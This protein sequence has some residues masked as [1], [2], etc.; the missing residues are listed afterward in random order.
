[1]HTESR[2]REWTAE[3]IRQIIRREL[4][5]HYAELAQCRSSK[6]LHAHPLYR[7]LK[8]LVR[9]V[10]ESPEIGH[11][12]EAEAPAREQYRFG[13]WN[14]ERGIQ[15]DSQIEAFRTHD[16][17]KRCD[18]LL[19]TETDVG[20]ARTANR[21]I[22]RTLARALGMHYAF[23]PCYL[24]L[25]KGA[26]AEQDVGG[27]NELGLHGNALLSRYPIR[28]VRSIPLENGI[29]KMSGREKRIGCQAAVAAEIQFPNLDITAVSVHLDANSTQRHRHD[30][31]KTILDELPEHGRVIV[32]GDWNTTTYN[33]ATAFHAIMGFWLRVFMGVDH[34]MRNHYLHPERRFERALFELLE[35]RG[36]DYRNANQ[37]GEH[38]LCYDFANVRTFQGLAEWVPLWCFPFIRWALRN[39]EGR[40]P[41]KLDWFATRGVGVRNPIVIHELRDSGG[42]P[43]SD[44]DLI[45]LDI[46]A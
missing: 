2:E 34:V 42:F 5:P 35:T 28:H 41:L 10:I 12:A 19:L 17:L 6:Q 22:A 9:R 26:G 3:E 18:V 8:P 23:V 27:E 38:T 20:M 45:G 39:H 16:Y 31:M 25:A 30:Q 32:G 40:C 11:F 21:D 37:L 44:H 13:A 46:I 4:R 24:N 7:K 29:D 33:S 15:L 14:I 43:L 36:F 1:M